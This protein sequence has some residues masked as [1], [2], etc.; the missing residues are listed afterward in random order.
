MTTWQESIFASTRTCPVDTVPRK[1]LTLVAWPFQASKGEIIYQ[2]T[3]R[4]EKHGSSKKHSLAI[5]TLLPNC[6][7]DPHAHK[8]AEESFLITGPA[9]QPAWPGVGHALILWSPFEKQTTS[10]EQIG[11]MG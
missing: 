7:S 4:L 9:W 10:I 2:Y 5:M 1:V 11:E 6:S 3:G 8:V